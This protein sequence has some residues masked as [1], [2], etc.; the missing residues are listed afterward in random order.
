MAEQYIDTTRYGKFYYKD[1]DMTIQ[2][3]TDGPAGEYLDGSK[4]WCL[5]GKL[6]RLDG[7]AIKRNNGT[8]EWYVD[9][10]FIFDVDTKGNILHRM[11]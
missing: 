7:P 9:G 10:I 5:N 6:H 2:H 4:V 8:T 1:P 3:R 11:R